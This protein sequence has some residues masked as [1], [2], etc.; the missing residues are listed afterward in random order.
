[1][2]ASTAKAVPSPPRLVDLVH[3]SLGQLRL[4]DIVDDEACPGGGQALDDASTD[5]GVAAGDQGAFAGQID[6]QVVHIHRLY[7]IGFFY[8]MMSMTKKSLYKP[9][10]NQY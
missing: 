6:L 3:H 5:A 4:T 10:C 7:P 2:S 1:M 8:C 9:Y